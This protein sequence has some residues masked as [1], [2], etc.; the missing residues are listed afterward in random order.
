L[1]G[2]EW[3][4]RGEEARGERAKNRERNERDTVVVKRGVGFIII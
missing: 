2:S 1:G 4:G 3:K